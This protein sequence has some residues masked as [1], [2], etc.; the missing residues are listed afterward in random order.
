M[1][2]ISRDL[3]RHVHSYGT[4]LVSPA[5]ATE[6]GELIRVGQLYSPRPTRMSG[7]R[8]ELP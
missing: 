8:S 3:N 7:E 1:G 6:F 5:A 4:Y 2:D